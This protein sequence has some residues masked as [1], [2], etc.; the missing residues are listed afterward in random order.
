[1][2]DGQWLWLFINQIIDNEEHLEKMCQNCKDEVTSTDKCIRCGK[3][4]ANDEE[5]FINPNF[6][7]DKFERLSHGGIEYE[8]GVDVGLMKQIAKGGVDIG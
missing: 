5:K 3:V 2:T 4:L 6:D 7:A 8:D 1:M